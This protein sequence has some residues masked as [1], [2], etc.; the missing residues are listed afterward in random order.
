MASGIEFRREFI[1]GRS[2]AL[3][4]V[5]D[6]VRKVAPS[7]TS[8]L[9]RGE[10]GTGKE[11]LAKAIHQPLRRLWLEVLLLPSKPRA[12]GWPMFPTMVVHQPWHRL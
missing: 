11:L 3:G 4:R 6:M 2:P 12:V 7:E 8:V 9:V 5:L 10:S 1:I